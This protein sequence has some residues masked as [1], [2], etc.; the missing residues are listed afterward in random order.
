MITIAAVLVLAS[1][2]CSGTKSADNAT[3]ATTSAAAPAQADFT[4]KEKNYLAGLKKIDKGLVTN[5]ERAI[6]RAQNICLDV[7]GGEFNDKQ[8]ADR[9]AERLSGGDA[10]INST[11]AAKVVA[12]AK[13]NIC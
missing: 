13:A 10:T 12:L 9:A 11:Q 1:T 5:E 8:L 4:A 7:K 6:R 3:P 2:A